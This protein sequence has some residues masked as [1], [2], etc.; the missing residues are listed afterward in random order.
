[1]EKIRVFLLMANVQEMFILVR[2]SMETVKL[3]ETLRFLFFKVVLG[4]WDTENNPDCDP[5]DREVC[6]PPAQIFDVEA[7][8][9]ILF[10]QLLTV[11]TFFIKFALIRGRIKSN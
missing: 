1:M 4:D 2:L 5:L 3:E 9:C 8:N 11:L 6:L 7:S 10:K